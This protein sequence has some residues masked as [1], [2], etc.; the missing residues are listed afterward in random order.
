MKIAVCLSGQPRT[1]KYS[2]DNIQSF[3]SNHEVDYFC[4]AWDYNTYKR[5]NMDRS[6]NTDTIWWEEDTPADLDEFYTAINRLTPKKVVVES[7]NDLPLFAEWSSLFYSMMMANH[8][9]KLFERDNNFRYDFV[10]RST[11]QGLFWPERKFDP[12]GLPNKDNYLDVYGITRN[13]MFY[14]FNRMNVSDHCFYG[15]STAMDV[16]CDFYKYFYPHYN[17]IRGDDRAILGPGTLL[18]DQC[19]ERFNLDFVGGMIINTVYRKEMIPKD[20]IS[21]YQEIQHFNN[22]FYA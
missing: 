16:F 21:D 22:T 11:Y 20:G 5:K 4:H 2:V 10:F 18:S 7:K 9:K 8:Y 13:R 14:E 3:F 6:V 19:C 1:I 12:S 17:T 15:S